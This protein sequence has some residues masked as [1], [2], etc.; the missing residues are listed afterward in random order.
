MF[1]VFMAGINDDLEAKGLAAAFV[2]IDGVVGVRLIAGFAV[3][4]EKDGFEANEVTAAFGV[5]KG[6]A[7]A[8]CFTPKVVPGVSSVFSV[9]RHRK[10]DNLI[11]RAL[12]PARR[13]VPCYRHSSEL[14]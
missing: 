7:S 8:N 6:I 9:T 13:A 1:A 14:G 5:F 4:F 10:N 12:I 11:R 3:G 2:D